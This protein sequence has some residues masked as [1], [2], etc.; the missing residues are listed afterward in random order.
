[1]KK[2]ALGIF[3]VI[4]I[5]STIFT[6]QISLAIEDQIKS[7]PSANNQKN[8]VSATISDTENNDGIKSKQASEEKLVLY[9]SLENALEMIET[10]NKAL[11]LTD[12]KIAIYEKQYE[13][14]L[15][16][17]NA[18]HGEVDADSAKDNRLNHKRAL[19]TLENARHD[20]EVQLKNLRA[21]IIDQYQNILV[22]QEQVK[23]YEQQ[24]K[25]VET[26]IKQTELQFDLGLIT[27]SQM[28]SLKYGKSSLEAGLRAAQNNIKSGM[29]ALK[30]DLGIDIN[31]EIILTS[32]LIPYNKYDDSDINE[33]IAKAIEN[34]YDKKRYN[35][36]I[37][38]TEIEY[39]I[40]S[41]YSTGEE[42][43]LQI[44]IEDKRATLESLSTTKEVS[45]RTAYNNLK[46]LEHSIEA[47][48]LAVEADQINLELL[49]K[50]ID[51]G[52]ASPIEI[53]Q[54]QNNLLNDQYTL[55]QQIKS[56][57]TAVTNF[58]NSLEQ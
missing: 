35:E 14:A 2:K 27:E 3:A 58:I 7:N 47:A 13:Q 25:N 32:D 46:S 44:S 42:D 36:D 19:W 11:Q 38:L 8:S 4:V 39:K 48:K 34:D 1:V 10:N 6:S 30:R 15:A 28:Y 9:L 57:N 23:N 37:E 20:R 16:K 43:Q 45:L 17:Y 33:K 52:I 50:K 56:Y 51:A 26:I 18:K 54:L 31:R 55:L 53:I 49:Q 24:I 5:S 40:A 12:S 22:L 29:I 41:D 21:Q